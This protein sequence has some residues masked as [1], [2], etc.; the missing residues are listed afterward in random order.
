VLRTT[1][2][3]PSFVD[4]RITRPPSGRRYL[5]NGTSATSPSNVFSISRASIAQINHR[6]TF[7]RNRSTSTITGASSA[8]ESPRPFRGACGTSTKYQSAWSH[9]MAFHSRRSCPQV[10]GGIEQ[11]SSGRILRFP[12]PT[13]S[14]SFCLR[15]C[16]YGKPTAQHPVAAFNT[17]QPWPIAGPQR[18]V[19]P[20]AV[21]TTGLALTSRHSLGT[22][23]R[24]LS[25]ADNNG[26][27]NLGT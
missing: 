19:L 23:W 4:E 16:R 22:T 24:H 9:L 3:A 15:G 12:T 5:T 6:P 17:R 20:P 27:F 2:A 8:A 13:K 7:P 10:T 21:S 14:I 25:D 11:R 1:C 26:F 18:G